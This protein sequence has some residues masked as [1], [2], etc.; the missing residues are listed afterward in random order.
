MKKILFATTNK[1]KV[2]RLSFLTPVKLLSLSDLP[3]EIIAPKEVGEDA[4]DIAILKARY[5]WKSLKEKIP[6]ITQD[7]TLKLEVSPEDDPG[8]SIKEPVVKRYGEFNDTNAI[9][10]YSDLSKKYG[11]TIPMYFEYGHAICLSDGEE[12][13]KARK[14]KLAGQLVVEPHENETT[15]GYFLAA[16]MQVKIDGKWKYYSEL[17]EMELISCDSGIAESLAKIL[18]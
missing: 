13:I 15:K 17:N 8:N 11:G 16:L 14:S 6:V 4:L 12:M 5:Y 10:Y 18:K 3:Y 2:R 1:Q 7:D 9:K